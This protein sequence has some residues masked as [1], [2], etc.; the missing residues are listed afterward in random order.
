MSHLFLGQK[1]IEDKDPI[2]NVKSDDDR[3]L[4]CCLQLKN[5]SSDVIL[6]TNDINLSTKA[7]LND[8]EA[9]TSCQYLKK[10]P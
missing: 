4:N 1:A 8:I 10:C 2:I 5:R 9:I 3:I 6:L 7:R